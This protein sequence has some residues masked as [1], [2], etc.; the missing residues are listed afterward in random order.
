[1]LG[2]Y[3][4]PSYN[5]VMADPELWPEIELN[6]FADDGVRTA[7]HG[8]TEVQGKAKC[9]KHEKPVKLHRAKRPSYKARSEL[10]NCK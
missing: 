1:M 5:R 7:D 6:G 8:L 2:T 3:I 10:L 4:C 9:C